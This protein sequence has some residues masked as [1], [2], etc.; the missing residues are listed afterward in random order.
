[1]FGDTRMFEAAI[2]GCKRETCNLP[3]GQERY[4]Y[5]DERGDLRALDYYKLGRKWVIEPGP[6]GRYIE[7]K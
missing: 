3:V 2:K 6:T 1:M 5:R 4:A 7:V